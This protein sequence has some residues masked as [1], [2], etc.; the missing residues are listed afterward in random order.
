[1]AQ[2]NSP[3]DK[4]AD[5]KGAPGNIG[6]GALN[7][8]ESGGG[9]YNPNGDG[10]SGA[11]STKPGGLNNSERQA[12]Q[13]N[14]DAAD[15]F[16]KGR[17]KGIGGLFNF[18][19]DEKK[20]L[21]S[22]LKGFIA[23]RKR[24]LLMAAVPASGVVV[25]L[26][27]LLIISS[28]LKLP[29]V[30]Q[31][32]ENYEFARV[33]TQFAQNAT[34]VTD[35]SLALEATNDSTYSGLKTRFTQGYTNLRNST[36]GR[37]DAY[38]PN[39]VIKTLGKEDGLGLHFKASAITG[40]K[41]LTGASI[42]DPQTG[43]VIDYD[44]PQVTSI[45]RWVPGLGRVLQGRN[46]AVF[47]AKSD[48]LTNVNE[49]M[50]ANGTA[51]IIR[52]AVADK[53]LKLAGSSR[54]GWIL[55]KFSGL[56]ATDSRIEASVEMYNNTEAGDT[57]ADNASTA[58][59]KQADTDAKSSTQQDVSS[60]KPSSTTPPAA[61]GT[62]SN[63]SQTISTGNDD[64]ALAAAD[65]DLSPSLLSDT[66]GVVNPIYAIFTPLCIV[67]D[68][69]VQHSQPSIDNQTNQQENAFD[70]LAAEGDQ[71]KKG[72]QQ[73]GDSE[74]IAN[75]VSGSNA[76][77][78]DITK[79]IPY[80][81][82]AGVTVDTSTTQSAE[83]G[84]DG[85]FDYSLYNAAGLSAS[86]VTGK[87]ANF[88]TEHLCSLLTSVPGA[89]AIA[90]ANGA[91][92]V[93]SFGATEAGEEAA[94]QGTL[95]FVKSFIGDTVSNIFAKKT[96]TSG[97]T[98]IERGALSRSLRFAFKQGVIVGGTYGMTE[99]AHL[100][101]ASR[102]GQA[103]NGLAQ[104]TDL[105][106]EADSGANI[107]ANK[108]EQ[109][110]VFGRP[111][112]KTDTI[113]ADVASQQYV[114]AQNSSKSF[115]DRYFATSNADSLV[116]HLAMDF[117]SK[118]NSSIFSSMMKLGSAILRP[119]SNIGS[120]LRLSGTAQAAA[121]SSNQHYG[122]V[123]FG[124]TQDEETLINSDSSYKPLENQRVLDSYVGTE[125]KIAQKYA[126]CFGY[127]YDPTG[128]GDLDPT[129]TA[130]NLQQSADASIGNLLANQDIWRDSDGNVLDKGICSP[131]NLSYNNTSDPLADNPFSSN[132]K[133]ND[134][135]FRWRL[136][137]SYDTTLDHLLS[138]Q[139]ITSTPAGGVPT[140]PTT[141][142]ASGTYKNP[143]RDIHN[144]GQ[145][146]VDQGVDYTGSG[147]IYAL[148]NG[149]VLSTT[150][151]GW[152]GGTFIVYQLTDGPAS[153]KYVYFAENCDNIK[154]STSPPNNTV[155]SDTVICTMV[156]ASPHI[157]IGWADGGSIGAAAAADVWVGHD[158]D[159]YYTAYGKNFSDLLH[160]LGAPSGIVH[161][162]AQKLGTL[163]SGWPTW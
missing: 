104:N 110:Q 102:A 144:L 121:S 5:E 88:V 39:E 145:S 42:K 85:S 142:P 36:W 159:S 154:V 31:N 135:V 98:T 162:G 18:N 157:E 82:A 22:R 96:T 15:A 33:T 32:I 35:E 90:L 147:P 108:L 91:A 125:D 65:A 156:D 28:A 46:T 57:I 106:N 84:S 152:P 13:G 72:D 45:A 160:S 59:I 63:L 163:P 105:V 2:G 1:M 131:T 71:Q 118:A 122:N 136:A 146:R 103:N 92:A 14:K 70:Q 113:Q 133:K 38:R 153:G 78:G 123:Q 74:K 109:Q 151:S 6:R 77:V 140:S 34:R 116:S 80:E 87:S 51:T 138:E 149:K 29:Q 120:L 66:L 68:G 148:G 62:T 30:T 73:K 58:E 137:M 23:R 134:L 83:A 41:I 60:W 54:K 143:F 107:E 130:G 37:V 101:V 112:N 81:R 67:F 127:S 141:P 94:G 161:A 40:R 11:K 7:K 50:K 8:A 21:G 9:L 155:T 64:G 55:G 44:I 4:D 132:G 12:G 17:D 24:K 158:S 100:A 26:A 61:G 124:W 76:E 128:N 79:S 75:A 49:A 27:F 25:L 99:L 115:T 19:S 93:A 86:S 53:L 111:L 114:D 69:S 119:F 139:T 16:G 20:P 56:D 47:L 117:S 150:N 52:G 43:E 89:A 129:D 126:L 10:K 95:Q 3:Y 97:V 48:F